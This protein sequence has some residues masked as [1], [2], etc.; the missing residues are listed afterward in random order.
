MSPETAEWELDE[1]EVNEER[2]VKREAGRPATSRGAGGFTGFNLCAKEMRESVAER[3]GDVGEKT[4][5]AE[6]ARIWLHDLCNDE[7]VGLRG[8]DSKPARTPR[9]LAREEVMELDLMRNAFWRQDTC[10][11]I[12]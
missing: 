7:K 10:K 2:D 1:I 9:W 4:I 8:G 5:V 3:I 12:R 6:L 11:R